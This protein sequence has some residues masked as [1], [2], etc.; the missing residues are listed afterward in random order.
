MHNNGMGY[1]VD[2][3]SIRASPV[4]YNIMTVS[5]HIL[6]LLAFIVEALSTSNR[7]VSFNLL[8]MIVMPNNNPSVLSLSSSH[9]VTCVYHHMQATR[10]A[11]EVAFSCRRQAAP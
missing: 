5:S 1:S 6:P 8:T 2:M 4:M 9:S 7:L 11:S 10:V 3:H